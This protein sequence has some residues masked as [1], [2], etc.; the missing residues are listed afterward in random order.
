MQATSVVEKSLVNNLAKASRVH[1][2]K[3]SEYNKLFR[4]VIQNF[5]VSLPCSGGRGT[6]TA[7]LSSAKFGGLYCTLIK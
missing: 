6:R 4:E 5:C 2:Y 7:G 1:A 3:S